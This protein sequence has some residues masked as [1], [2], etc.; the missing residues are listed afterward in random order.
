M[1]QGPRGGGQG[2]GNERGAYGSDD[3]HV[4]RRRYGRDAVGAKGEDD[5][6]EEELREA[7]G[8]EVPRDVVAG[9]CSGGSGG[10]DGMECFDFAYLFDVVVFEVW[11]QEK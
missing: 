10:H 2:K 6:G 7:E 4:S 5:E 11:I 8:E 3:E 1:G 9:V